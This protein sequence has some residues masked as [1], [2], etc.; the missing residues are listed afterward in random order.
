VFDFTKRNDQQPDFMILG[1][2]V[3]GLVVEIEE[4][5]GTPRSHRFINRFYLP[6]CNIHHF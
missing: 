6:N 2:V 4:S 5:S 1:W 3:E